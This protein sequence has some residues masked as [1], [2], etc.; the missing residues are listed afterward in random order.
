MYKFVAVLNSAFEAPFLI[1]AVGHCMLG[2]T[3]HVSR[4]NLALRAFVDCHGKKLG[5]LTD[6][7]FIVLKASR[8][9]HLQRLIDEAVAN[10]KCSFT[11]FLDEHRSDQPVVQ[12]A[13]IAE[14]E[15]ESG[16]ILCVAL[17]GTVNDVKELTK[18]FSLYQ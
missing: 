16:D 2:L 11:V 7:P 5:S 9:T 10:G 8:K 14:R 6:H 3:E 1:N 15:V 17:F 12:Q 18:R 13:N 4:E